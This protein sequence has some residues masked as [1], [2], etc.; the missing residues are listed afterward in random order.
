MVE[1][2][3]EKKGISKKQTVIW[4]NYLNYLNYS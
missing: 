4:L 2:I 1:E 3:K